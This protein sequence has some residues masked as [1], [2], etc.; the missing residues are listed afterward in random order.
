VSGEPPGYEGLTERERRFY[1]AEL[2]HAYRLIQAVATRLDRGDEYDRLE[3]R[4]LRGL[5]GALA[6]GARSGLPEERTFGDSP[7]NAYG[8]SSSGGSRTG[9]IK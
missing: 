1:P 3:A 5:A 9:L 6:E 4:R 2:G 8:G 7:L